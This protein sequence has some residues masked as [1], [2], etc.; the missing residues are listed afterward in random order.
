[1]LVAGP[2]I[3]D[4]NSQNGGYSHGGAP[5]TTILQAAKATAAAAGLSLTSL[6]GTSN[7]TSGTGHVAASDLASIDAAVAA[8]AKV[9]VVLLVLG[10]DIKTC[11]EMGAGPLPTEGIQYCPYCPGACDYVGQC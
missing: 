10:D 1:M 8:A 3:D 6:L 11:A 9:D 5:T 2:L 4:I 7:G